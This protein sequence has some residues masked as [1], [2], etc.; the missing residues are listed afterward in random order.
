MLLP[1]CQSGL[2]LTGQQL[3]LIQNTKQKT[4]LALTCTLILNARNVLGA[5]IFEL[6][7]NP[8]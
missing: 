6:K 1:R 4:T 8:L 5:E 7:L 2:P 3:H